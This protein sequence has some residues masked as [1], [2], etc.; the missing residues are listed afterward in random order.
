MRCSR[1]EI[2]KNEGKTERKQS[3]KEFLKGLFSLSPPSLFPGFSLCLSLSFAV[4]RL[5]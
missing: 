4:R 1:E 3:K 5:P 2:G